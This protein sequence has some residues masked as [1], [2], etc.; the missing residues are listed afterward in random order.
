MITRKKLLVA[1]LTI[2]SLSMFAQEAST[3]KLYGFSRSDFYSDT[4]KMSANVLDLFSLYPMYK[5]INASGEDLN[6]LSS[7]GLLSVTTRMGLDFST[8]AGIFGAKTAVA[9]I[10]TD[11]G[12]SPTYMLLRIRQAYTQIIWEKSSLLV[13]QTWHPMFVNATQPNVLS[14]NTGSPFQPFNRSPQ[15]RFDYQMNKLKLTAAA[16]YQMMYA[17]QGPEGPTSTYQK[18]AI[19][20]DL[21]VSLEYKKNNMLVGLGG[22][23]KSILPTRYITDDN[24]I[25]HINHNTLRTPSIMVFGVLNSGKLTIK[26]KAL[27]GQN[28]TEHNIIGGYSITPD[29]KYI[30][31]NS[32]SSFI[33][34][35]YGTTH[36]FGLLAGFSANLGPSKTIPV[37]SNFYG[38]GVDGTN[39]VGNIFRITPT[40][41]YNIKNWRMGVELEYT[42]AGWGK[43]S[44]ENG[45]ILN[46]SRSDNYRIYAILMYKF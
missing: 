24:S 30:P 25:K 41:S 2:C 12:G 8:P 15:V 1:F 37:G 3:Y 7:A 22:D 27:F 10:E 28:L 14:L 33:H 45:K 40:Y 38:L 17:S 11:F 13:G 21:F 26:A 43:R 32:F 4:R 35:N 20:P 18:N 23:Y 39:M 44:L 19:L 34:F 9:K 5:D 46:L 6:A 42:N 31:Y 16:I 36:Q 29:N